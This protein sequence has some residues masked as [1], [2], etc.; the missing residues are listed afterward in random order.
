M[1]TFWSVVQFLRGSRRLRFQ[2]RADE[3]QTELDRMAHG[4]S[5]V[6]A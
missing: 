6:A 5:L 4:T 2:G 1:Q 3:L